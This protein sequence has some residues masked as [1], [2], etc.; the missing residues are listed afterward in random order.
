MGL[1]KNPRCNLKIANEIIPNK[2]LGKY[3]TVSNPEFTS[4]SSSFEAIK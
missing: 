3:D 4:K 2:S 1:L